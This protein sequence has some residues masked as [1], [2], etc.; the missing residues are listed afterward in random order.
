MEL[1]DGGVDED[2][3]EEG[4]EEGEVQADALQGEG[5]E[6]VVQPAA[7]LRAPG[8]GPLLPPQRRVVRGAEGEQVDLGP[9][10][11]PEVPGPAPVV[12]GAPEFHSIDSWGTWECLLSPCTP[13][14]E[15]PQAHREKWASGLT[16]I[17]QRILEAETEEQLTRALKWFLVYPQ[18]TLRQAKRSGQNGRGPMM[19][20]QRFQ[21]VMEGDWGRLLEMLSSDKEHERRRREVRR[22]RAR[23]QG[24]R[25]ED[26]DKKREVVLGLAAKGQVGRAARRI[27]SNGVASLESPATMA[28]LRAKYPDRIRPLP[29]TVTRGQCVDNLG[30]LREAML[31]L[32]RGVSSG[33]GGLRNEHLISLAEVWGE[34]EMA[35]LQEFGLLYLNSSLPPWF[36]RV[37]GTVTT[38]PLYKTIQR[39][40]DKLRPVGVAP[41]MVRL[42]DKFVATQNKQVL[43][44]FLEPQQ[45]A[46]SPAGG[47]KLVHIV[48]MVME[49]QRDWVC[50]K[51]DV[52]NAHNSISRAA[53]LEAVEEEPS[54]RHLALHYAATSA[55][56]TALE[57]GGRVWGEAK[58]A[59]TQGRPGS[60]GRYCVGWHKEVRQIDSE[61]RG[62][63]AEPGG[64][65]VFG[66]DDGYVYGPAG[67]V[68]PAVDRFAGRIL[69]RCGLRL[70][71]AKT[72]IFCW[73]ELPPGTPADMKRAGRMVNGVF[74]PG[75]EVYGIGVGSDAFVSAF[76]DSKVEEIKETVEKTCRL[77]E[78]DL[79]AKWTFLTS[80]ICHKLSYHLSLQYPSDIQPHAERLD[81]ILWGMLEEATG[82]HI[83]RVEEGLG[84]ECVLEVPVWGM[85]GQSYQQWLA[86]LPV[87]ERG[88]GVRSLV[89]TS[90][91]AFLGSV[92]MALPFLTG[93]EGLCPLLAATIGDPRAADP[94][95]RWRTL[96]TSGSRT[97]RE[98][99]A[100][101]N[102]L[103]RE[104]EDCSLY[105]GEELEGELGVPVEG[106]G[107]GR[108]DGSTR[109]LVTRQREHLRARVLSKAL[110]EHP[111]QEARPTWVFPQLDKTACAWLLATPSPETFIPST[112]FREAMAAHLCLPSPCCQ[113]MV[114][115]PTGC[116]DARGNPT[117]VDVWGDVVTAATLSFDT[118][119]Q[120]HSD[121]QRAL[122]TRAYEARVEIESEVFGCFRDIIP[123][124]VM[125]AGGALETVRERMGCV[126]DLRVGL[127]VPLIPRPATY[128]PP[129]GRPAAAPQEAAAPAP[130]PPR[131]AP[132]PLSK[133][134]AEIKICGAGP[135][136]Y[137]RDRV[138]KAMDRRARQLPAE[139]RKK[140]ADID[141]EYYGT[142]RGQV[143]P[144]QARLEELC[145]GS[146]QDLLGLCV[147]A[148]GD[149]S[150][151]LERLIKALAESRALYLSR[152]A[153]RPL[154][155]REAGLI[156]GQYRRVLSVCF[157]RSNAACLVARM[158]HLG[159]SARECAGRRRVAMA[160]G[161]R[162]SQ[163][164]AA[165]HAA[166][167]RGR[168]RWTARGN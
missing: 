89:D 50:C 54:L 117:Y 55:A 62:G 25:E 70:Q 20:A 125:G 31:G 2:G 65:A 93:E 166:H 150:T 129:R 107:D 37:W 137:P 113:P 21:A 95:S 87:R 44:D 76:L 164:A 59:L 153:G 77:L 139:Y 157:V 18:A 10:L 100:S 106:V 140:V 16:I 149:I 167:I 152:E 3:E 155:D 146:L 109:A 108:V 74:E 40:E 94:A 49:E 14:T 115:K 13:M 121:I 66:N 136:R 112:L 98:F 27:D 47:H 69:T 23:G 8:P 6:Q 75:M 79:Q 160:E 33:P 38:V 110:V 35:R 141:Q 168:G 42:L 34:E 88:M 67:V 138:D 48:R 83:P 32:E 61:V 135:T 102:Q 159:E 92:E 73:G 154:S 84:V 30:G 9:W 51:L 45:L 133:Y 85:E 68:Y 53:I 147:G 52:E 86:R 22:R 151:D 17:L 142:V 96:T 165:Y 105:L 99:A 36:Y 103:Q 58:E 71:R 12:L 104:A 161:V 24:P 60:S 7:P 134:L 80:S 29:A 158:G 81:T 64:G 111:D 78:D 19:V 15:V 56:P 26:L 132:G 101:Y 28:T 130:R 72:E 41:T 162:M 4:D 124:A 119:R 123:A 128:Y 148:F 63:G 39:E 118:W 163:E 114:G 1:V 116:K 91:A 131:H 11:D 97:G 145:G 82:L 122:V 43:Q 90:P 57:S 126:P 156:L 143:G 144:L 5:G 46:L 120:R 127:Q